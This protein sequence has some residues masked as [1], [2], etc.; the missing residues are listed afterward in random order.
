MHIG[1]HIVQELVLEF[2]KPEVERWEVPLGED[3]FRHARDERAVGHAHDVVLVIARGGEVACVRRVGDPEGA[4][5]L[6]SGA[7]HPEESFLDGAAREARA[8]TGLDVRIA[9]YL[10]QV[11]AALGFDGATAEW[12]THAMLATPLGGGEPAPQDTAE[13]A[14]ARFVPWDE[15]LGSVRTVLEGSGSGALAYRARLHE[16]L[17]ALSGS[18]QDRP[19]HQGAP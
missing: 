17:H 15:L 4:F 7:I 6:P 3:E 13:I 1:R 2:G 12:T 11:H 18:A 19:S 9:D 5:T 8:Q 10:L 14:A 16:R